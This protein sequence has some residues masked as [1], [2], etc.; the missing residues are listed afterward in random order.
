MKLKVLTLVLK[1]DIKEEIEDE[2]KTIEDYVDK[3]MNDIDFTSIETMYSVASQCLNEKKNKRP[4]IKTVIIFYTYLKSEGGGICHF[5]LKCAFQ[6]N[7]LIQ[8]FLLLFFLSVFIKGPT[9]AAR[10]DGFL[11]L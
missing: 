7:Y 1:L 11:K 3:K 5:F 8:F 2:E 10:N 6:N 4:D 9:A